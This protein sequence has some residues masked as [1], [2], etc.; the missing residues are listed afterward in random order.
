MFP[1]GEL[2]EAPPALQE[3]IDV[4]AHDVNR[5]QAMINDLSGGLEALPVVLSQDGD[6]IASAGRISDNMADAIARQAKR[7]WRE[8]ATRLAREFIR[9]EEELFEDEQGR[10]NYMIYSIHVKGALTLTVGWEMSFSLTQI[11]A[12]VDAIREEM[13]EIL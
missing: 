4:T 8:G 2:P 11:R 12:E 6:V 3:M 1:S 10:A 13:A 9:F 7:L 5:M